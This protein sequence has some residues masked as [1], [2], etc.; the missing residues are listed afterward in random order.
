MKGKRLLC[1]LLAL[2]LLTVRVGCA[3]E[4]E[5]P[6][7][8]PETPVEETESLPE[9]E[10]DPELEPEPDVDPEPEPE[11]EPEPDPVPEPEVP[12]ELPEPEPEVPETPAELPGELPEDDPA[13]APE[14]GELPGEADAPE[15]EE[16]IAD[17]LPDEEIPPIAEEPPVINVLLPGDGHVVVNPYGLEVPTEYGVSR[18]QV[19]YT[20]QVLTNLSEVP[21]T[22]N[23]QVA[24]SFVL[25]SGAN[26]VTAPPAP[27]TPWKELFLYAEF[28]PTPY[29]W[30]G[31]FGDLPNQVMVTPWGESKDGVLTLEPWGEGWF[32]LDGTASVTPDWSWSEE[33]GVQVTLAFSFT[34]VLPSDEAIW[35]A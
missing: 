15:D 27:D 33:D 2:L 14:E 8:L 23:V 10:P 17:G 22:V 31:W 32:R 26:L 25:G 34:P 18:E 11:P 1:V 9:P 16:E 19:I 28:Q 13:E 7:E 35:L 6:E 4:L 30:S 21:V 29:Q 20:P 3:E 24:G 12:E 5:S